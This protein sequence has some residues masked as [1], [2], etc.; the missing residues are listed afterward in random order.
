MTDDGLGLAWLVALVIASAWFLWCAF[1][2]WYVGRGQRVRDRE[3]RS[4]LARSGT[5]THCP[6]WYSLRQDGRMPLHVP[7]GGRRGTR[8]PGGDQLPA[9]SW[10]SR[11]DRPGRPP[12]PEELRV[13]LDHA[14]RLARPCQTCHA[15][16][17]SLVHR[18]GGHP[19]TPGSTNPEE[20]PQP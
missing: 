16:R 12:T 11:H 6:R 2:V 18:L 17:G 1:L 15:S 3:D 10:P 5:C 14:D 9:R 13:A 19:W 7:P 4:R 20:G 8:C